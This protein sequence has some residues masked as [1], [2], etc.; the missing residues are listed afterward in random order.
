ML[1]LI[2]GGRWCKIQA[3]LFCIRFWKVLC[4]LQRICYFCSWNRRL[5]NPLN[6]SSRAMR[7]K[8]FTAPGGVLGWRFK[9]SVELIKDDAL[10]PSKENQK[11]GLEWHWISSNVWLFG[12]VQEGNRR[13]WSSQICRR[14]S[15]LQRTQRE[16]LYLLSLNNFIRIPVLRFLWV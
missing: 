6:G 13:Q 10:V 4:R 1:C 12:D 3:S 2:V 11:C 9:A 5:A 16:K 15:G 14:S 7:D 8:R